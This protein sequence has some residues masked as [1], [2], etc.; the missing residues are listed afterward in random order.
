MASLKSKYQRKESELIDSLIR[1]GKRTFITQIQLIETSKVKDHLIYDCIY[2]DNGTK[3]Q[4]NII[5][6]DI[7][8]A[9]LKVEQIVDTNIPEITANVI[10]GSETYNKL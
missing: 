6:V 4:I 2:V 3:K 7:S 1:K 9:V 5:A 8:D 10:L